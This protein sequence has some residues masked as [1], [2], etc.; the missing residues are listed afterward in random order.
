MQCRGDERGLGSGSHLPGAWLETRGG[1]GGGRG[2]EAS[3]R[4]VQH[5][6]PQPL[7]LWFWSWP[8]SQLICPIFVSDPCDMVY[9]LKLGVFHTC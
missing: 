7:T 3:L 9:N 8:H 1:R 2:G 5:V 4:P 6:A